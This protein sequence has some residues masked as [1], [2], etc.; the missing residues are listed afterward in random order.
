M[1]QGLSWS[2]ALLLVCA[3]A[4]AGSGRLGGD[5]QAAT[6]GMRPSY[7]G[8]TILGLHGSVGSGAAAVVG[9]MGHLTAYVSVSGLKAGS[10]H[11][12]QIHA[13]LCGGR[14]PV[15]YPLNPLVADGS[16]R[17]FSMT[18]V[19][20]GKV[21]PMGWSVDVG[22]ADASLAPLACGNLWGPDLSFPLQ[23]ARKAR[24][25]GTAIILG[26]MDTRGGMATRDTGVVIVTLMRG[27]PANSMH[28]EHLHKGTCGS[29]GA[30][31]FPLTRWRRVPGG[32]RCGN[33]RVE[34][35][36]RDGRR[37]VS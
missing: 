21:Q 25:E 4:L 12:E 1:K 13:G 26:N 37:A 15:R 28:A 31:V 18:T 17:A 35:G 27:L 14:G 24:A 23:P 9:V 30:I 34:Y 33:F 22:A 7:A 2:R 10:T 16:G 36:A 19:P 29:D 3:F 11:A 32:R 5:G 8:A 20:A 6:A